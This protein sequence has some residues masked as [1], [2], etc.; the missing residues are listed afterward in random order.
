MH[1]TTVEPRAFFRTD[2]ARLERKSKQT[3]DPL[4]TAYDMIQVVDPS[5]P[6]LVISMSHDT[7][8]RSQK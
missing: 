6:Q 2:R 5:N 7:R 3:G 4:Q 1:V 8:E